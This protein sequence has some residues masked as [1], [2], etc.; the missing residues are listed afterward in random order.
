[1]LE[2]LQ[3]A[4][5]VAMSSTDR[6]RKAMIGAVAQ[7]RD[8]VLVHARNGSM[9]NP[10]GCKPSLHAEARVLRKAGHG[11]IVYVCRVKKDG[12]LAMAKPCKFC[13]SALRSRKV[14]MVYW[15]ISDTNWDGC[16]P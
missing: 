7:R 13:M 11:A 1:M 10:I 5:Q 12:S 4:G 9:L 14:S 16:R 6:C 3:I 8:G 15:S 2:L